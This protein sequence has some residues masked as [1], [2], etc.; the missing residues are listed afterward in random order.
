M[1]VERDHWVSH[2]GSHQGW[3]LM[4]LH[5]SYMKMLRGEKINKIGR[6]LNQR[7]SRENRQWRH[8]IGLIKYMLADY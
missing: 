4:K 5:R 2:K 8:L 1:Q 6:D 7:V 3:M